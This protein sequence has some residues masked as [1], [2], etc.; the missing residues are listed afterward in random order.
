[1]QGLGDM[2][3]CK[4]SQSYL[5]VFLA[6]QL[7]VWFELC[8]TYRTSRSHPEDHP[9]EFPEFVARQADSRA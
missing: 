3:V 6:M 1:M 4:F 9:T 7:G 2:H 8:D 5:G